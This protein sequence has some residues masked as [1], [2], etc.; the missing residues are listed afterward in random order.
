MTIDPLY[1]KNLQSL[2]KLPLNWKDILLASPFEADHNLSGHLNSALFFQQLFVSSKKIED[3]KG[4]FIKMIDPLQLDKFMIFFSGFSGNG[5]TTFIQWFTRHVKTCGD[6]PL[7]HLYIDISESI[8]ILQDTFL[9]HRLEK[10]KVNPFTVRMRQELRAILNNSRGQETMIQ[11]FTLILEKKNKLRGYF[12]PPFYQ[13][14]EAKLTDSSFGAIDQGLVA[15]VID[16]SGFNDV[17]VLYFLQLFLKIVR[18]PSEKIYII[19][20]DNLDAMDIEFISARFSE[21]FDRLYNNF[22]KLGQEFFKEE[23]GKAIYCKK[24]LRFV[25]ALRDAN[26]AEVNAHIKDLKSPSI[27]KIEFSLSSLGKRILSKRLDFAVRVCHRD[28]CKPK[29]RR[30]L[31]NLIQDE[32]TKRVFLPL[33]NFDYRKLIRFIIGFAESTEDQI[34]ELNLKTYNQVYQARQHAS[35]YGARGILFYG[36]IRGLWESD[37]LKDFV[38]NPRH[39]RANGLCNP[40]RVILTVLLDL[41]NYKSFMEEDHESIKCDEVGL[42]TLVKSLQG[43]YSDQRII[44]LLVKYFLCHKESWSHLITIIN[45]KV[46]EDSDFNQEIQL[47]EKYRVSEKNLEKEEIKKQLNRVKVKIN[48]SGFIYLKYLI[49]H[50]EFYSR[51][52]S[53]RAPLFSCTE[54]LPDKSLY[55]FEQTIDCVFE[56]LILHCEMMEKFW[57]HQFVEKLDFTTNQFTVSSFSFKY[58]SRNKHV[59]MRSG[60]GQF[61]ASRIVNSHISYIDEFRYYLLHNDAFRNQLAV[62]RNTEEVILELQRINKILVE[63]IIAYINLMERGAD[64]NAKNYFAWDYK[65]CVQAIEATNWS[66]FNIRISKDSAK[67]LSN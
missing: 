10:K 3:T 28:A 45:K 53:N 38:D 35:R 25:F 44:N 56:R 7:E 51:L 64:Q 12:S 33:F 13:Q 55:A 17:F 46:V 32:Y 58:T 42:F 1:S 26:S 43:I 37:F 61:H 57:Q 6:R 5:K 48:P 15:E 30:V 41:C 11:L 66:D 67:K 49:V 19:Y 29:I 24:Q 20:F 27:G 21:Q 52:V 62:N 63:K 34:P 40:I 47:L 54:M 50:F 18:N 59:E 9:S 2:R 36:F 31:E 8:Y 23:F 65:T 39:N 4:R 16:E 14:L 60:E 22:L